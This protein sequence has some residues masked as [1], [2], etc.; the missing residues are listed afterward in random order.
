MSAPAAP[1]SALLS[2]AL[3]AFTIELDNEFE[4]RSPNFTTDSGGDWV[5]GV[6][7][8]SAAMYLNCM[9]YVDERGMD[10]KELERLARTTPNLPGMQRWR[11]VVVSGKTVRATTKGLRSRTIWQPL[12]P[13]I[14]QR[15]ESRF[16]K[17]A[18]QQ[19]RR[20]LLAAV[21]EDSS[22]PDCMPILGWAC[23]VES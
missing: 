4:H 12:F 21:P 7:A 3:I 15:W 1:V 17:R 13:E 6:W 5:N 19:L 22:L 2:Q 11:Y 14:E 8:T 10:V 20:A 16:G 18:V 23:S 9:R